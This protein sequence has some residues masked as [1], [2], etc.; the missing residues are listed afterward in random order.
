[1]SE[2]QPDREGSSGKRPWPPDLPRSPWELSSL[3]RL[4]VTRV[5]LLVHTLTWERLPSQF[6]ICVLRLARYLY[7]YVDHV[8]GSR[9]L[10]GG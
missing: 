7:P 6:S 5:A 1:M 3:A 10:G 2:V 4:H 9:V 8:D